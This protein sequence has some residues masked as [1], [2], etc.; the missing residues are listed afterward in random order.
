MKGT[1]ST[2][3]NFYR[4][5]LR[6]VIAETLLTSI[7]AGFSV[8]IINL[9]WASVGMN[10][11]DIGISQMCFTIVVVLLDIPMGY[12]ADRFNRKVLNVIGDLGAA[13]SFALYAF[14]QN[15]YMCILCECMLGIFLSMTNGV[16]SS[17]LKYNCDA[18]DKS[19]MMFKKL[20]V[21][22][23]TARY[24]VLFA[25]TALGGIIAKYNMRI[26]VGISF[27][28]YFIGSMIAIGIKDENKKLKSEDKNL[29]KD[30]IA[31]IKKILARKN[32]RLNLMAYV[33]GD[34][35]T[36]T[37]IWVLTPLLIMCQVPIEIVSLGWI[38]NYAMQ[39]IGSK[40]SEK[41]MRFNTSKKF[42]IPIFVEI[43]WMLVLIINTNIFTVWL[44]GLNGFVHG[45]ISGNLMTSLQEST[46]NE[47]QT[48]V[49]SIASTAKRLLYIPLVYVMN[50]LGNIKLQYSLVGVCVV[51]IPLCS[52]MYYKLKKLE[53][54]G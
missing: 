33:L 11:T 15:I 45:L 4:K 47:V 8:P 44:F 49:V 50:Y 13:L 22:I 34:E 37:Q 21:K 53:K 14:S 30:L 54:R 20:N 12:V 39:I 46:P 48:S 24:V 40:L 3:D 17:F 43:A 52:I 35:I 32:T 7:G 18:L 6:K 31:S 2:N 51:F 5:N 29:V 36:H 23:Y 16:D 27:L 10:Q 38:L 26:C 9:F 42:I 41:L 25:V 19:G 28:P 1:I